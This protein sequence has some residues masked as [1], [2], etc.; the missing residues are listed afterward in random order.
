[1]LLVPGTGYQLNSD[2]I[3]IIILKIFNNNYNYN[4]N[5]VTYVKSTCMIKSITF[6]D[7]C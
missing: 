2:R 6:D 4:N 1:M 7:V 5:L 3:Y